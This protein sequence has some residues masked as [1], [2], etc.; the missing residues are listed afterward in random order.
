MLQSIRELSHSWV[1]K[2]LMLF[3][4]VS[5]S[6]WG[7][8]DMFR[9]NSLQKTVASVSGN[10]ITVQ[11]LNIL[12][13]KALVEARQKYDPNLTAERARQLGLLDQA[14]DREITRQL[15]DRD[16]G[17]QGINVSA[18]VVLNLL[19]S[20]PQ[21][22]NKDGSFN[23]QL[24]RQLLEQQRM[25][26][27]VFIA[28]GQQDL[29]RQLLVD[30]L[31]GSVLAPQVQVDALYKARAQKRIL[32]VVTIDETK[33]G[34]IPAPS[35]KALQDFY[36][37]K[38][39]MFTAPEYRSLTVATLSTD[40]LT[41]GLSITDDQ[42]KKEY[43]AKRGQFFSPERRDIVQVV[44]QNEEKAKQ[45]AAAARKTGNLPAAAKELK[46]TAVPINQIEKKSLTPELSKAVFA[47]SEGGISDP[48][49]SQ[50][51]WH[52][53]MLKKTIPAGDQSFDRV[54]DKLR[55]DMR[56]DQA[57]ET[58]TRVV[59]SLD[60]QLAAGH[61]LDDIADD[62]KLRLIK[63]PAVDSKGLLP[64]G[65]APAEL[66]NKEK[67]L[68]YAFAQNAGETSPVEDNKAGVYFVVRTDQI[69]PSGV[70]PFGEVKSSVALAWKV[71]EQKMKAQG[72]AEKIAKALNAGSR[73]SA[74]DDP[75]GG[76][77]SRASQP[78]SMLGDTDRQLPPALIVQAFRLKKGETATGEAE[79]KQV[80]VR[81]SGI[82]DVDALRPDPR[83]TIIAAELKKAEANELLEQ[84]V[85]H[86]RDVFPVKT[87]AALLD[88][89]RQREN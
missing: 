56:H 5:F 81:L 2:A 43:D 31:S 39:E 11:Q 16:I 49:K 55:D 53:V 63:I 14:L 46:E 20:E 28:Q 35:G 4:I 26:E 24:F 74:F 30:A 19:A 61:S 51:G 70:R 50:L 25:S 38:Q 67:T 21:F 86:L 10:A 65:K 52:V 72:L 60:D 8:G 42:V 37:N 12:F 87:N 22:R 66:P 27:G 48:V 13:E 62:L 69:V 1:V 76:I 41:K 89:L 47:L 85:L 15:I 32:D 77:S 88:Q 80:V 44:L 33:L 75:A 18:E 82:V 64:N 73:L 3:L 29:S 68:E 34:G 83:K 79:G 45:V 71:H 59:N 6:I 84:Y 78:L 57:I 7:I 40:S 54:K 23:K 17:R 36:D 58:A 9:G